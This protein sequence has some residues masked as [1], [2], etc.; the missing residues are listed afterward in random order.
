MH[1]YQLAT[2]SKETETLHIPV[3]VP[4]TEQKKTEETGVVHKTICTLI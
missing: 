2:K 1:W 4:L 3:P